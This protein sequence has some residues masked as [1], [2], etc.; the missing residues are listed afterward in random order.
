[1]RQFYSTPYI[2][3]YMGMGLF[4]ISFALLLITGVSPWVALLWNVLSS[5]DVN[6]QLLPLAYQSNPIIPVVGVINVFIFALWAAAFATLFFD[7]IK[8]LRRS[9]ALSFSKVR[10]LS[11]HV[12]LVPA[13]NFAE[14]LSGE[15]GKI[16]VKS[17]IIAEK[18]HEA[19]HL[20]RRKQ[21]TI[22]GDPKSEESFK[23]AG[24]QRAIY[25]VACDEDDIQNALITVT[26]KSVK[27]SVRVISR[28]S[29]IDSIPKLSMAG[30]Y[31]TIMPEITTGAAMGNAIASKIFFGKGTTAAS[32][33]D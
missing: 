23:V 9:R 33:P 22:I 12:I 17:V 2:L 1:M 31:R 8:K 4:F 6:Y 10:K 14:Y 16:G 13:N 29:N 30:A 11:N 24:V 26:A 5:L 32:R 18:E 20:A 7:F 15:L 28:V 27:P 21:L 3:T 19:F 25:V